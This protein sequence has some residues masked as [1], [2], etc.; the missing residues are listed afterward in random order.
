MNNKLHTIDIC[1][2][3]IGIAL[4]FVFSSFVKIP[5]IGHIQTD[6][7]YIV[8]GIYCVTFG[9][10]GA[11]V[12]SIGCLIESIIYSG[13][14][15]IGWI[16]GQAFIGITC[17]YMIQKFLK[18]V[19]CRYIYILTIAITIVSVVIGI[20]IIKTAVECCLYSIPVGIKLVKNLVATV[21]D[22][23][24]MILGE[25]IGI[26]LINKYNINFNKDKC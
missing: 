14:V 5:L 21:A 13:F 8:F 19:K 22:I 11:I 20:G 12:G 6:M 18:V 15:P 10:L 3:G 16:L 25:I 9:P 23:P 4:Y 2:I 7:G 26:N 17:G 24:P 1:K